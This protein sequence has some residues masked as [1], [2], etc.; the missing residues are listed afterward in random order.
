[1]KPNEWKK[2][3]AYCRGI[4]QSTFINEDEP[5]HIRNARI[6]RAKKDYAFFFEY[7][8]PKLSKS[9]CAWYHILTADAIAA[10]R[11]I[12]FCA[13]WYRGAAKS[14]HLCLGIPLWLAIRGERMIMILVGKS[15]TAAKRLLG[16]LQAQLQHNKRLMQD[17]GQWYNA[18]NWADGEFTTKQGHTFYAMGLEQSPRGISNEDAER[19]TYI[20]VS[21]AD[22]KKMSKNPRLVSEAVEWI[23]QDLI[24]TMDV[25]AARFVLDNNRFAKH[26]VMSYITD[27]K[28]KGGTVVSLKKIKDN[29]GAA[30]YKVKKNWHYLRVNAVDAQ[31]NPSWKE[32]YSKEYWIELHDDTDIVTW[33]REYMNNPI[34]AGK[35]FKPA[36]INWRKPPPLHEFDALCIYIDTSYKATTTSDYKAMVFLGKIKRHLWIL[37]ARVRRESVAQLARAAYDW[38]EELP[39]SVT[40]DIWIEAN[41]IQDTQLED[42][43]IEGDNRREFLPIMADK[44]DKPDKLSRIIA[45]L[46][47]FERGWVFANEEYKEDDDMVR[48]LEQLYAI[49]EGSSTPDDFPDAL[50]GGKHK[51]EQRFKVRDFEPRVG[52]RKH[53]NS[54]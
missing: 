39:E 45:M 2:W 15:E 40:V 37:R 24:P 19:P 32:K 9:K 22:S 46:P 49:E 14:T 23:F 43:D 5:L 20:V 29:T 51:L 41:F 36:Q 48:G 53:S 35:Y 26:S 12:R 42:F 44:R 17:F 31:F 7:Y 11:R 18:G 30:T 27:E 10:N 47:V 34:V 38:W 50:E 16:K 21:D 25:G 52:A 13:E 3:E 1:M 4:Q 54:Y 6:E 33:N 28:L 8:F